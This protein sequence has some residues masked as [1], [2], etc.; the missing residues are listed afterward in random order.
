MTPP[1]LLETM[2][3]EGGRIALL[4][5]HLVRL[6]VSAEAFGYPVRLGDV[7]DRVEAAVPEAGSPVGV[8]LTVGPE[9]DVEIRTWALD[10]RPFR[11][12]VLDPEPF[13]EAGSAL[14]VHKTT[15][16]EHYERRRRRSLALGADEA[17]L[18]NP[19]GEVVEGTR[20]TVWAEVDGRL[21]TPP[22]AAGGLP[23]VMRAHVLATDPRAGERPLAPEDLNAAAAVYLSNALRSWMPVRL[24]GP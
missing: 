13:P 9:G 15:A 20:T 17:V 19:R 5:R 24:V 16:R 10:D 1:R 14:C 7:R 18:V 2:R 6:G 23:G 4:D 12:A 8:R 3:A 22:L 11:L 21:W